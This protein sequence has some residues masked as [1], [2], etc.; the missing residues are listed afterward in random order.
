MCNRIHIRCACPEGALVQQPC[1]NPSKSPEM[2]G[3]TSRQRIGTFAG[4]LQ[5]PEIPSKLSCCLHTAEVAGS[6]PASPTQKSCGL[7]AQ[8]L[9]LQCH[10]CEFALLSD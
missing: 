7:L 8:S 3:N 4:I 10:L 9:I 6:N 1:S 2:P 5:A